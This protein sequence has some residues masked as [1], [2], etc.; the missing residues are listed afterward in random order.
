ML[1][2]GAVSE[3]DDS[4]AA[5]TDGGGG[6]DVLRARAADLARFLASLAWVAAARRSGVDARRG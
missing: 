6:A 4:T 2:V 1:T 3:A 5:V